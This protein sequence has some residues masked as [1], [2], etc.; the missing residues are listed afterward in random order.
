MMNAS[1]KSITRFDFSDYQGEF[2][3]Q[4]KE[5]L[6]KSGITQI[7]LCNLL[8][9][10]ID[11]GK[12]SKLINNKDGQYGLKLMGHYLI[13]FVMRRVIDVRKLGLGDSPAEKLLL[14]LAPILEDDELISII[15]NARKLGRDPKSVL[16]P[17]YNDIVDVTRK[18]E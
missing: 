18:P 1:I 4:V 11:E 14:E 7:E 17:W 8:G 13:L 6:T 10:G 15:S 5:Y 3:R 12:F 2:E 9:E 16:K